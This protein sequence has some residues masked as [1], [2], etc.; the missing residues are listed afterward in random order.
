[1]HGR[2][3]VTV[4]PRI[5]TMSGRSTSGFTDQADIASTKREGKGHSDRQPATTATLCESRNPLEDAADA[6]AV[7]ARMLARFAR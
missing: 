4:D 5:S 2:S 7:F 1:M 6:R 3:R